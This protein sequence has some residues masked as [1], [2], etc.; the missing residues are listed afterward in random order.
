[1]GIR[2][3]SVPSVVVVVTFSSLVGERFVLVLQSSLSSPA[4]SDLAACASD[5]ARLLDV[6]GIHE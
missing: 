1:M 2:K 4:W 3:R 5:V 6:E